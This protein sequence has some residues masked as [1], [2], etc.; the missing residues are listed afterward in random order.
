[1]KIMPLNVISVGFC[2]TL[3][4]I[5]AQA[6]SLD[7]PNVLVVLL[8]DL[9]IGQFAPLLT[10]LSES[11]M[12]PAFVEYVA[13]M[14]YGS[15]TPKEA[16]VAAKKAMPTMCRLS[17]EGLLFTRAF[18]ASPLCGPSRCGLA[19]AIHPNR[20]GI[21]N[22]DDVHVGEGVLPPSK[23]LM[24]R[25]KEAGYAT[26]H[27]GKWHLGPLDK[28]LST[29][30]LKTHGLS[31]QTNVY[32][33]KKVNPAVYQELNNIGFYGSVPAAL[34]PLNNGFETYYGYNCH[35]SP[36][37]DAWN[38]WDGFEFA[39]QQKGYNT[40]VFTEKAL[41]F[42]DA[43]NRRGKPFFINLHLHATH[44]PMFPNPPGAYLQGFEDNTPII[45]NYYSHIFA[46]D[47]S[48]RRITETLEENGQL[49]NTLIVFTSDNGAAAS[50]ESPLPGNAP[51]RGHKAQ[52]AQG[53]IRVPLVI[54]WPA[55]IRAG[56]VCRELV[57]LLDIM[58]TAMDAA[59]LAVP[60]GLDGRSLLPLIQ[61]EAQEPHT[62]LAWLGFE[63]RG[64][65][66]LKETGFQALPNA[67]REP[68][69]WTVVTDDWVLRF[70]GKIPR[71]LYRDSPEGKSAGVALYSV[72]DD[73]LELENVADR[74]PERVSMLSGFAAQHAAKTESPQR[75]NR[76]K[77]Q[78]L[79]ESLNAK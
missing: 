21:Y 17:K 64:W 20:F 26:A 13:G 28:S 58:P 19:T 11:E 75:W 37:Y 59:G 52:Y 56:R 6:D 74:Y 24:P 65:G 36:F 31:A 41:D 33:L 44:G 57:S 40:E 34:N 51:H 73:P 7:R 3:F 23:L 4:S 69:S 1:M 38:V 22:N 70:T 16:L 43:A 79:K 77:W 15:Y 27:F 63:S 48:I 46:V 72:K 54:S 2:M 71:G 25:F 76:K 12:D 68:G 50:T 62:Y 66:F 30:V 55:R 47:E 10:D 14:K 9:G 67:A 78:E 60:A 5:F 42:M 45:K 8:D 32:D 18:S 53:G 49:K 35:E 29:T 61:G 39:G